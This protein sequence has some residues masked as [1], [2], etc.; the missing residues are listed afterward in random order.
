MEITST[1]NCGRNCGMLQ[2]ALTA[3]V[4][5][6]VL[7]AELQTRS[8]SLSTPAPGRRLSPLACVGRASPRSVSGPRCGAGLKR[9][10]GFAA[11]PK[12][13]DFKDRYNH[14]WR[15]E[16]LGFMSPH[17]ARQAYAMRKTA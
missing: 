8:R 15:L 13:H 10:S 11:L 2:R 5:I 16:K 12:G 3:G 14:H 6:R 9:R 17:E 7:S 4:T 1:E